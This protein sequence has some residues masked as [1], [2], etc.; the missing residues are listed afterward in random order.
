MGGMLAWSRSGTA[1]PS[2]IAGI[3]RARRHGKGLTMRPARI[4]LRS[5]VWGCGLIPGRCPR[6]F[7]GKNGRTEVDMRFVL[8]LLAAIAVP[9]FADSTDQ[10]AACYLITDVDARM[11]C[12]ARAHKDPAK[13]YAVQSAEK[14][15]ICIAEVKGK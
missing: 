14:R 15:A 5:G 1:L 8:A 7:G 10:A 9:A 4:P 12:L 3:P 2:G 11:T 13:C 6:G